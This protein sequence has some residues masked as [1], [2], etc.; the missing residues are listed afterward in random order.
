MRMAI[1]NGSALQEDSKVA[2]SW[3]GWKHGSFALDQ[4]FDVP[5]GHIFV[6][7]DKLSAQHGDSR[8]FGAI[9]EKRYSG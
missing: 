2:R 3:P 6:L 9:A 8:V 5:V 1:V 4:N 7:S